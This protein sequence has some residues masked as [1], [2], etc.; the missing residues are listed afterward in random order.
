MLRV[1]EPGA[2]VGFIVRQS[3]SQIRPLPKSIE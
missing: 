3:A 2:E 1:H